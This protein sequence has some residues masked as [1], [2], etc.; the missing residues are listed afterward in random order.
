M[1]TWAIH[2][3]SKDWLLVLILHGADWKK[4]PQSLVA[5]Q[6][7]G[8]EPARQERRTNHAGVEQ[9]I[10]RI[11][12]GCQM[13]AQISGGSIADAQ[14]FDEGGIAQPALVEIVDRFGMPVELELVGGSRRLHHSA[15]VRGRDLPLE[16]GETLAEGEPRG[17]AKALA[18]ASGAA[19]TNTGR[20]E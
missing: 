14:F 18:K 10:Q 16:E 3:P 6:E 9:S 17:P 5:W 11:A 8:F 15:I 2:V 12:L 20:R 4:A 1:A 13:T 19:K 7:R